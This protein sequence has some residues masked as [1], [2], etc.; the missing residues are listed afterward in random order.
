MM[1]LALLV[2]LRP[3]AIAAVAIAMIAGHNM[4]DGIK[5][6]LFG[7]AAPIWNLLHQPG[8]LRVAGT[9]VIVGYPFVPW[10]AVM[11]LGFCAGRIFLMA[12]AHR[13]R[14]LIAI[15]SAM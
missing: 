5:P 4:L 14:R 8:P 7:A 1:A 11:T 2:Y 9:V 13:Q 12:P 3:W 10:I 6:E 15:G